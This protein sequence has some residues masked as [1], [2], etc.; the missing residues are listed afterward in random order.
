MSDRKHVIILAAGC[1][2]RFDDSIP[3]QFQI[4]SEKPLLLYAFEAFS[5][6]KNI[7]FTL[8]INDKYQEYWKELCARH[9]FDVPH[10]IIIGG[11]E[12]FHSVKSA[13]KNVEDE[14]LVMIHDGS[15]PFPSK[16]TI[17]NVVEVASRKGNAVPAIEISDSVREHKGSYNRAVER[18]KLKLIQTPQAFYG[19]LIRQ[20][21]NQQFNE[22]FTDDSTVF[23]TT[24]NTINLVE[25]NVENIKITH[26]ADIIYAKSIHQHMDS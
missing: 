17:I 13:L 21:Y 8:V 12:R 20:A 10:D 5:F 14:E 16:N 3:K 25:G 22:R 15:R 23:E 7:R 24:G 4:I 26:P 1:G 2:S 19:S 6:L 18:G 9:T 11:P